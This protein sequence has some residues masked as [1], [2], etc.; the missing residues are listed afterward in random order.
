MYIEQG[1]AEIKIKGAVKGPEP[2]EHQDGTVSR[3]QHR[4]SGQTSKSR[5]VIEQTREEDGQQKGCV[6]HR[7]PRLTPPH[8][9]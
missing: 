5:S 7:T 1:A 3:V 4:F 2:D 8:H 6:A 9:S